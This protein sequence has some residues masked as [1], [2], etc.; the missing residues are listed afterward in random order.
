M[1]LNE[2]VGGI[3]SPQPLP[4]RWQ[5]LLA[6]GTPDSPVAHWTVTVQCPVCATSFRS[7]GFG[8]VDHWNPLS[9]CCTGQSGDLWLL[10]GTFHHC[11]SVQSTVGAQ[12]RT[13]RCTPDSLVNYSGARPRNSREWHVRLPESLV[14]RTLSGAHRTLSGAPFFSTLKVLRSKFWLCPQLNF[15][16]GLCWT[17]CTWDKL[18]LDKLVSPCGLCWTS[19]TKIDYGKWLSPFPFQSPPF[20]WL[21]PTLTK[22]NMK[23]INVTSL[24]LR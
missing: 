4:S 13:V 19:T 10:R 21:M 15:F 14:H 8:A 16:L 23:C 1:A 3:Y 7:L 12:H 20:W 17:L 22:E 2:V 9:F 5:S 18:Y 11:S 24:Q 6:V